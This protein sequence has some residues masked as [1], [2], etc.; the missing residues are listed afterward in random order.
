MEKLENLKLVKISK[1]YLSLFY[2]KY[3]NYVNVIFP[4]LFLTILLLNTFYINILNN[5]IKTSLFIK[6]ITEL[7]NP[8]NFKLIIKQWSFEFICF[9]IL[10]KLSEYIFYPANNLI[11]LIF[12]YYLHKNGYYYSLSIKKEDFIKSILE[13]PYRFYQINKYGINSILNYFTILFNYLFSNT[14]IMIIIFEDFYKMQLNKHTIKN[15]SETN[16]D[17]DFNDVCNNSSEDKVIPEIKESIIENTIENNNDDNDLDDDLDDI[18]DK[19][20]Q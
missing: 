9:S 18:I 5:L 1:K 4:G 17:T 20:L 13:Y 6:S 7:E 2:E 12:Y 8:N 16:L 15:I 3:N 19:K 11:Y 14:R 10:N